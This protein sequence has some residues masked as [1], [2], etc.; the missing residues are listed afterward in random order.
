MLSSLLVQLC[1]MRTENEV[2]HGVGGP[3]KGQ[4]LGARNGAGGA[5]GAPRRLASCPF[6]L[7]VSG[8][9]LCL[10]VLL[11]LGAGRGHLWRPQSACDIQAL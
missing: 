11:R 8:T 6:G 3:G 4:E 5:A 7:V 10:V 1:K 2:A 9:W